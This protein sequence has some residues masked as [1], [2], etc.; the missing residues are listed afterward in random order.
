MTTSE[1][2]YPLKSRVKLNPDFTDPY[3]L[4]VAGSE[5]VIERNHM[6]SVGKF[7][8]VFIRWDKDHWTYN[9]QED[10]WT[11]ENHF[12]LV[13]EPLST[14]LDSGKVEQPNALQRLIDAIREAKSASS[15]KRFELEVK[16][17]T[18]EDVL[19]RAFLEAKQAKAFLMLIVNEG[20]P[21]IPNIKVHTPVVFSYY[22]SEEAGLILEAQLSNLGAQAHLEVALELARQKIEESQND[23]T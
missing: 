4:A 1:F 16:Q 15:E 19:K 11:F 20:D 10:L 13:A 5:G 22:E 7:P 9:G 14:T 12:D 3:E 21:E 8:M 17:T 6:E 18:Y 23:S 2:K